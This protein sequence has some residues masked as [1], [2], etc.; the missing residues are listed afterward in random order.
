MDGS[1]ASASNAEQVA[2]VSTDGGAVSARSVGEVASISTDGSA[3]SA[4]TAEEVAFV[5]MDGSVYVVSARSVAAAHLSARA[6]GQS[7]QG[8]RR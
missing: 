2:S 5:G 3:V 4:R 6:A 8:L 7:L 1:A